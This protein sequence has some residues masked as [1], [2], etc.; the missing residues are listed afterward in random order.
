[1]RSRP[2]FTL[3]EL[4]LVLCIAGILVLLATPPLDRARDLVATRA[5]RDYVLTQLA[6][7]RALAPAHAGAEVVLDT[8]AARLSV[9]SP[10]RVHESTSLRERF[11]VGVELSGQSSG[12]VALRFDGMGLGRMASRTVTF[13]RGRAQAHV[14]ISAYG[15]ARP[16]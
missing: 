2:G 5:A 11:G 16:W 8:V 12:S 3:L 6:L 14:S 1:M 9:R 10:G 15:R 13:R 4:A 7:A